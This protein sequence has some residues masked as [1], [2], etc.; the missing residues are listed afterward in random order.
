MELR[1]GDIVDKKSFLEKGLFARE[2]YEGLLVSS[3]QGQQ[4]YN[5]GV[6]LDNGRIL[7]VD[8]VQ[9]GNV[10]EKVRSWSGKIQ[11]IQRAYGSGNDLQN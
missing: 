4:C 2:E 1:K 5:L 8:Q 10:E 11:E 7:V 9:E 6:Q 3:D